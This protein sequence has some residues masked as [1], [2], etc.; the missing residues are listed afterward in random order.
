[1]AKKNRSRAEGLPG[2]SFPARSCRFLRIFIMS[3]PGP[4][5][6]AGLKEVTSLMGASGSCNLNTLNTL[7]GTMGSL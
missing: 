1:M 7:K 6:M 4:A 2:K 3:F 5:F